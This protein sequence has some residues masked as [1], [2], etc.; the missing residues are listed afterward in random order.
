MADSPVN[1]REFI[2]NPLNQ[3]KLDIGESS[4]F[5]AKV[6]TNL[7]E[8]AAKK[9]MSKQSQE[10]SVQNQIFKT[11]QETQKYEQFLSTP[12]GNKLDING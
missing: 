8:A 4:L 11:T 2:L 12:L 6:D 10:D 7:W 5:S 3:P 9:I 1:N